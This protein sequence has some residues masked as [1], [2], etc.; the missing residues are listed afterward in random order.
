M[1]DITTKALLTFA[2]QLALFLFVQRTRDD[3]FDFDVRRRVAATEVARLAAIHDATTQSRCHV[4]FG[5]NKH[6]TVML[7]LQHVRTQVLCFK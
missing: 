2:R 7:H 1:I 4:A 3:G 5:P 6:V